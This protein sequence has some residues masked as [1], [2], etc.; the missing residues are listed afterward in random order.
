MA[1]RTSKGRPFPAQHTV[2]RCAARWLGAIRS[3]L[4][5][6][7]NLVAVMAQGWLTFPHC[8]AKW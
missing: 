6:A 3:L 4:A 2:R 8:F 7:K 5:A 1:G